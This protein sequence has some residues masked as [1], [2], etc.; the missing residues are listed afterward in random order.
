MVRFV[1][2]PGHSFNEQ[3]RQP[4]VDE[5]LQRIYE[6]IL[7]RALKVVLRAAGEFVD[8]RA[9]LY[10]WVT[11]EIRQQTRQFVET[12]PLFWWKHFRSR[13]LRGQQLKWTQIC[14]DSLTSSMYA[15]NAHAKLCLG[16]ALGLIGGQRRC[17]EMRWSAWS[18]PHTEL[19]LGINPGRNHQV[20][21]PPL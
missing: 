6:P 9:S 16:A 15:L 13:I 10:P 1:I 4:G 11:S 8:V 17:R 12:L 14:N 5:F 21:P 18:L 20:S 2:S 3:K 7:W 19:V